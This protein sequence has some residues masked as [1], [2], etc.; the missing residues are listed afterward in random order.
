MILHGIIN[1]YKISD[2]NENSCE[3]THMKT[4]GSKAV[5]E[6]VGSD[7]LL[8]I[9]RNQVVSFDTSFESR[10]RSGL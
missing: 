4:V 8:N 2:G 10:N 7:L 6:R 3:R 5:S 9:C 1:I